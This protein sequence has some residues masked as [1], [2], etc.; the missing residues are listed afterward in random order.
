[1]QLGMHDISMCEIIK[2]FRNFG[3]QSIK[4]MELK[5][6]TNVSELLPGKQYLTSDKNG[7]N[8]FF[9][10]NVTACPLDEVYMYELPSPKELESSTDDES[11][12]DEELLDELHSLK[13]SVS[14]CYEYH[15][16]LHNEEAEIARIE[17]ILKS[18]GL[19]SRDT[20]FV[21]KIY[22]DGRA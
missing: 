19:K 18:R 14:N 7:Y 10:T 13:W 4:T 1:M 20:E 22:A 5:R 6:I 3:Q 12:T 21:D 17:E 11:L 8:W 9:T 2:P 15:I 16:P